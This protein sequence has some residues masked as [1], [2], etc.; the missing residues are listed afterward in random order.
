MNRSF[1]LA[2][3]GA[4]SSV[5]EFVVVLAAAA[6]AYELAVVFEGDSANYEQI[7]CFDS[8]CDGGIAEWG[9]VQVDDLVPVASATVLSPLGSELLPSRLVGLGCALLGVASSLYRR[10]CRDGYTS[11]ISIS[12][13][14]QSGRGIWS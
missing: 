8:A 12:S 11:G 6:A 2:E 5:F 1:A 3:Q 9:V 14:G 7:S 13:Q 4:R 10:I